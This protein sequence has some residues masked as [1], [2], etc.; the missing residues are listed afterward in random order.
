MKSTDW[1]N[2]LYRLAGGAACIT[3]LMATIAL[4]QNPAPTYP[5]APVDKPPRPIVSIGPP[6]A[7]DQPTPA[8]GKQPPTAPQ[9]MPAPQQP[10]PPPDGEKLPMPA[11]LPL[12]AKDGTPD[13]GLL[14]G[15]DP[16]MVALPP[17]AVEPGEERLEI[18]LATALRLANASAWDITIAVQQLQIAAA[19]LREA[20]VLW[21]PTIVGGVDYNYHSGPIQQPDGSL[22]NTSH[23]NLYAGGAPLAIFA[24]SDAIFL[25]LAQRQ[26]V[27]AQDANIQTARNDTLTDL[28]QSYFDLLQAEADMAAAMDVDRKTAEMVVKVEA[29]AP[30]YVGTVEV[31]RARTTKA[32]VEQLVETARQ[33][34]RDASAEVARIA[35]LKPTVVLQPL[36]P[37]HMRITLVPE[38]LTPDEL[39]PIAITR[40]PELMFFAARSA[41][42]RERARQEKW[43]PLLPTLVGRGAGTVPPYPLAF[44]AYGGGPGTSLN[45]FG[46]RSDWDVEAIWVLQNMGLGNAALIRERNREY[47]LARSNEFRFR[48]IVARDVTVAWAD[49][50]SASRRVGQAERELRQAEVSARQNLAGLGEIKRAQGN[51]NILVIRPQEVVSAL[52]QLVSAYNNYYATVADYNR[53]QFRLYRALGNPAQLLAG[54]NGLCGPPLTPEQG[55]H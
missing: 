26:V 49:V 4:A 51:I 28:S 48:D 39:I 52:Q 13:K 2:R 36:E 18:N 33:R 24:L 17:P 1:P 21:L 53:A 50:R 16:V 34:W 41:E 25:P 30:D 3:V 37:P 29:M 9:P 31:A 11:K 44:G 10:V 35:R 22:V 27:R 20:Q 40:R 7:V 6:K 43:R 5:P 8:P 38:T 32:N 55:G 14:S 54:H 19:Q 15:A 42:A 45:N 23:S 46:Q 47:D 12:G